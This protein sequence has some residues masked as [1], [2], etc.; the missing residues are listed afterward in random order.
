MGESSDTPLKLQFD[1]RVRLDYRGATIT[2]DA[3]LL[4]CRELD[5]ALGLTETANDY[6]H[7][8]RTGRNLQHRLLPLLRQSVSSRLA[9]CDGPPSMTHPITRFAYSLAPLAVNRPRGDLLV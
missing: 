8:S 3:G 4:A 2:S 6:I 9:G 1:C 5:A 7:E